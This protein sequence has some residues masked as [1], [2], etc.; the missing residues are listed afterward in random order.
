MATSPPPSR[1]PPPT[2]RPAPVPPPVPVETHPNRAG[3]KQPPPQRSPPDPNR[4]APEDA[5]FAHSPL[6]FRPQVPSN[7]NNHNHAAT[8]RLLNGNV[9]TPPAVAALRK[10]PAVPVLG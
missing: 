6:R 4:L 5:Y 10:P 9:P 8:L 2:S 7:I 1:G 3:L